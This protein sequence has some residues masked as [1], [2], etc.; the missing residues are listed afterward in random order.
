MPAAVPTRDERGAPSGSKI[1]LVAAAHEE[2]AAG[3]S[4]DLVQERGLTIGAKGGDHLVEIAV[5][6]AFELVDREL[7]AVIADAVLRVVVGPDLLAALAGADHAQALG[8][9]RGVVLFALE[10][11]EAAL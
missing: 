3:P 8:G 9:D 10:I 6:H 11:E 1:V 4:V 2:I 7:D 5:E